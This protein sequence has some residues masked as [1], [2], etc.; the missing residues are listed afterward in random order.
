A[1]FHEAG[2]T[3]NIE[4]MLSLF[5]DDAVLAAGGKTHVG[6][7]QIK[8]FFQTAAPSS[9]RTSG[10]ATPPLFAFATTC[11][12]NARIS[13]LNAYGSTRKPPKSPH[14]SNRTTPWLGSTANG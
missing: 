11:K 7:D 4:L 3:K 13:T 12:A 14:K 8:K 6:K 2:S 9:R 5:A 10:S 1:V